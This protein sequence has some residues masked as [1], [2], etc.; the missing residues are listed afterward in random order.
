M[1]AIVGSGGVSTVCDV[2]SCSLPFAIPRA[3]VF[4]HETRLSID[5]SIGVV[6]S[7]LRKDDSPGVRA[8]EFE[9][10]LQS[11]ILPVAFR[12]FKSSQN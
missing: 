8:A 5:V 1:A 10:M 12:V 9:T 7:D 2:R 4:S 6:F 11:R 3:G